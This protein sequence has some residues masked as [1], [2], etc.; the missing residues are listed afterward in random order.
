M[1]LVKVKK[2]YQVTI[3]QKLRKK[4][5]LTVGDF[6]ELEEKD[7]EIVFKPVKLVHPDQAYYYSKEW[8]EGETE[9]DEAIKKGEVVGDFDNISDAVKA[10]KKAK[11]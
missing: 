11:V 10:L 5:K 3:P 9:A 4:L 6:M 1:T 2:N 7:N 8:Q